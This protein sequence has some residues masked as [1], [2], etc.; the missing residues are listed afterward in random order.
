MTV[1]A[2]EAFKLGFLQRCADEGLSS[3]QTTARVKQAETKIN[4]VLVALGE[5]LN[6]SWDSHPWTTG[7]AMT[8]A[9]VGLPIMAGIGAG[10]LARKLKGDF[11]DPEDVRKQEL[12]NEMRTLASRSQHS[13][14]K[15]LGL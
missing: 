4:D 9:A 11:L 1:S 15:A 6:R 3:T 14:S 13:Q 10:H 12:I 5:K 2:R 8:G 7:G